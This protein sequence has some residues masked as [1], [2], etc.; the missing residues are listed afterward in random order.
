MTE[1]QAFFHPARPN[2]V[3]KY[4]IIRPIS[5][6]I[7]LKFQ[8]A[9]PYAFVVGPYGFFWP[10]SRKRVRPPYGTFIN[11][12]AKKTLARPYGSY[13]NCCFHTVDSAL[14]VHF[15]SKIMLALLKNGL[16]RKPALLDQTLGLRRLQRLNMILAEPTFLPDFNTR[17]ANRL[18]Y[19]YDKLQD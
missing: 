1:S 12:F 14:T 2:L 16:A 18:C 19:Q 10:R 9:R 6:Q 7:F 13:D 3:N 17:E 15:S 8:H 4:F 5:R 11:G